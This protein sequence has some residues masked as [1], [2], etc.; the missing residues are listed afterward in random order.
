MIFEA[1]T[2]AKTYAFSAGSLQEFLNER[3]VAGCDDWKATFSPRL[4]A[5]A[6]PLT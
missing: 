2:L 5:Y 1:K 3:L 6:H 4:P